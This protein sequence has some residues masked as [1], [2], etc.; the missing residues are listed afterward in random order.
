[1]LP[2]PLRPPPWR[3][4]RFSLTKVKQL[5]AEHN[6]TGEDPRVGVFVCNCGINIGGYADVPAVREYAK[7]LPNVVHVEDNLFTCSQDTQ[8]QIRDVIK[9]KDI[10]R[11]VVAS[12]SPRTHEAHVPGD[13]QRD[14]SQQI[15]L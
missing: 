6:L 10:T 11:V 1:M 13:H 14:R 8:A 3:K 5:P 2:Q 7:T 4:G 12:C 15:P 9:E